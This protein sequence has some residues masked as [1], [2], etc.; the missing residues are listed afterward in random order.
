M[1]KIVFSCYLHWPFKQFTLSHK[2]LAGQ[3][4]VCLWLSCTQTNLSHTFQGRSL[5]A[6][7]I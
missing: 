2:Y 7:V 5:P 6:T 3:A 1:Q 4:L